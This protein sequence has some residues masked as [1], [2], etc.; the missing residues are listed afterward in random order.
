M[1]SSPFDLACMDKALRMAEEGLGRCWP[2]PSVGCVI[3][4]NGVV[5]S[6]ARTATGGRPHAE[7]Q[8]IAIAG[9][10]A[11]GA[12]MY[13]TLEPCAHHG[14]TPPCVDAIIAAGIA[15]VFIGC[16]DPDPRVSGQSIKRLQEAGI[17]VTLA[18]REAECRENLRGFFTLI[19][20][21]RPAFILKIASSL[22]GRITNAKG[23]SQ[24]ITGEDSRAF[25]HLLR[26]R[27][28]AVL[29]GIG[30]V[31]ADNPLL[32]VRL[33]GHNGLQ[34]VR[35]VLDSQLRTPLNARLFTTL[36]QQPLWIL[37]SSSN[38]SAKA[39]LEA[40]GA[41]VEPLPD[42]LPAT[43]AAFLGAKGITRVLVEAGAKVAGSFMEAELID[44]I[45]WFHAPIVLG[46]EGLPALE[47]HV[48][49][50]PSA[51]P[52]MKA[53]ITRQFTHDRMTLFNVKD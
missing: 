30:T 2:N 22:D 40:K 9:K 44:Q 12:D 18:V 20:Q 38:A 6:R 24:W 37:T 4:R 16:V 13:V 39:A 43:I 29:T 21:N 23:E 52:R 26:T 5:I 15:R 8:A 53:I 31:L 1:D 19:A 45:Y 14:Q 49:T 7:P 46:C 17:S 50:A 27:H 3:A 33:N 34:P 10:Q 48:S 42:M 41:T 35:I 28:D 36:P 11:Q 32:N 47:M 25:V 51:L